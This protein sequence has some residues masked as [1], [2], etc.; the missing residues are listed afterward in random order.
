[1][2]VLSDIKD[3]SGYT[4]NGIHIFAEFYGVSNDLLNDQAALVDIMRSAA[5]AT[6]A[7]I[8]NESSHKFIPEGVTVLLL[9]AE[10]HASIHTYPS[11]S[12]AFIDIFTCGNCD[13]SI[14]IMEIEKKLSPTNVKST[15]VIRGE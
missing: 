2:V 8:L 4:F 11:H 13:P 6:G 15:S 5:I 12:A 3:D 10:S 14:A 9:L 7:T 1:M